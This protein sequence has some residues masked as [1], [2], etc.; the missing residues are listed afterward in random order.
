MLNFKTIISSWGTKSFSDKF[1][2]EIE[3]LTVKEL[4]LQQGLSYSNIA[5]DTDI[6]AIVLNMADDT[7]SITIKLGL[8][9]T[10]VV[11]GCNCADDPSPLDTQNEYCEV[12]VV[13]D[14][15][16]GNTVIKLIKE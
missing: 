11:A 14:K 3:R 5:L 8:F 6:K 1:K 15:S 9:Y 12:I 16:S 4:P 7:P 13:I 2:S 10:G